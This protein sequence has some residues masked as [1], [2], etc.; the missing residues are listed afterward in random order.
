[1][2]EQLE[3]QFCLVTVISP[4]ASPAQLHLPTTMSGESFFNTF[5]VAQGGEL[6]L[7]GW[8][9]DPLPKTAKS[10]FSLP[11]WILQVKSQHFFQGKRL[12][13]VWKIDTVN[14]LEMK[15]SASKEK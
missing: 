15:I 2:S 13:I 6:Y 1:M 5:A 3:Q 9:W 4:L 7:G 8:S 14:S 10:I 12:C 11:R